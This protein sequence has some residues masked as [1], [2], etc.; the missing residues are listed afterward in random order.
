MAPVR[1]F[2]FWVMLALLSPWMYAQTE[3]LSF[4]HL[5]IEDGLSQSA[6][7]ALYQ[8]SQGYVWIGT[9][10]GLN[11]FDGY[12]FTVYQHDPFNPTTISNNYITAILEDSRKILWVG[13]REKGLNQFER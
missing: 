8:D 4:S 12:K 2:Y 5:S 13:T 11:K 9:K 3:A 7:Y 1:Y 10:D 6:V